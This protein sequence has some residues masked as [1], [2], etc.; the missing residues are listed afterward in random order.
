MK[1]MTMFDLEKEVETW[2]RAVHADRCRA[3]ESIAELSDHLLCEIEHGRGEGLSAEQAFKAAVMKLGSAP[4]LAAESA[5]NRSLLQVACA[6]TR[7]TDSGSSSARGLLQAHAILW[8]A[9]M[10]ASALLSM[11]APMGYIWLLI[12]VLI[13]GWWASEQILRRALRLNRPAGA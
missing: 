4:Q 12:G 9:V 6:A 11:P 5:K 7:D 13:P 2:S 1:G 10:V 3:G 8:A